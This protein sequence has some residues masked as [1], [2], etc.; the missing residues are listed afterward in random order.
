MLNL[1]YFILLWPG[2][3]FWPHVLFRSAFHPNIGQAKNCE[4]DVVQA[5]RC[6]RVMMFEGDRSR[7]VPRNDKD[8]DKHCK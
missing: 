1:L 8:M 7:F 4:I 3:P 2:R 6:A 5:D